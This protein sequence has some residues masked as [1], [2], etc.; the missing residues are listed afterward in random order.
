MSEIITVEGDQ[1]YT[2]SC[3][4]NCFDNEPFV[5]RVSELEEQLQKICDLIPLIDW[6]AVSKLVVF[7]GLPVLVT[8]FILQFDCSD[9]ARI[10][11]PID[12]Q[13]I[14]KTLRRAGIPCGSV[15][16]IYTFQ[17]FQDL[18]EKLDSAKL[19][20]KWLAISLEDMGETYGN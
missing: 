9:T 17:H 11:A 13:V 16:P 1:F 14:S 19:F 12:Q 18:M 2:F 6:S 20:F 3:E 10:K 4:L 8:T 5:E 7:D 15:E